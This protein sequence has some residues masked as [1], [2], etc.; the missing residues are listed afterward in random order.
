MRLTL[1]SHQNPDDAKHLAQALYGILM[2]L[3]QTE[4]FHLLKNRL[5]S[6]PNY[7]QQPQPSHS[8][9]PAINS[10]KIDF[11]NLLKHFKQ[12]QSQ[13]WAYRIENR[14]NTIQIWES[15]K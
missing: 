6:V 15:N 9:S 2:L 10:S 4:A 8:A 5:Q 13:H 7:W 3:P 14:K 12:V 11:E 1:V